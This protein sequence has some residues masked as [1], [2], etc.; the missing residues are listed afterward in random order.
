MAVLRPTSW[1]VDYRQV[2]RDHASCGNAKPAL[3]AELVQQARRDRT[4][5][6]LAETLLVCVEVDRRAH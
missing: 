5:K 6:R 3:A 2:Y 4:E 1:D